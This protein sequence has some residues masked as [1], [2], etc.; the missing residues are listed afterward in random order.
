ML[1]EASLQLLGEVTRLGMVLI[2][3]ECFL[4]P[5]H[6]IKMVLFLF[7]HFGEIFVIFLSLTEQVAVPCIFVDAPVEEADPAELVLAFSTSHMVATLIL[8]D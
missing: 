6:L 1:P 2:S 7:Q 5:L 3:L 8:F 4:V